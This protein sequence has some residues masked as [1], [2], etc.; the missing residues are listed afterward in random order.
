VLWNAFKGIA[1]GAVPDEKR[2]LFAG[3][4]ACFCRLQR[5]A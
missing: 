3:T 1:A 4:A 2:A 5:I